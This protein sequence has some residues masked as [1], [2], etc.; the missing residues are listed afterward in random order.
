MLLS[1]I[2]A[3]AKDKN[4]RR[5]IGKDNQIPWHRP[6]DLRRFREYTSGNAVIMGRKTYESIGRVLPNRDNIVLTH[7]VDYEVPGA[8]VFTDLDSAIRFASVRNY[9][10]FIIGGQELYE[11]TIG[12]A[13]RL[14]LTKLRIPNIEGDTFFPT[15]EHRHFKS[16]YQEITETETFNIF[17]RISLGEAEITLVEG[18]IYHASSSDNSPTGDEAEFIV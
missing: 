13:D 3:Y 9:E 17:Q 14:Y 1:L 11:Q 18:Y 15:V 10:A 16:I 4:G 5:V 7:Q 2:A 8:Y 6:H 12:R